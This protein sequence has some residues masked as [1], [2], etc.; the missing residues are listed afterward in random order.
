MWSEVVSRDNTYPQ[1]CCFLAAPLLF[2]Q[3][4]FSIA[5]NENRRANAAM[6]FLLLPY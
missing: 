6:Q 4:I 5:Q 3:G 2:D 1:S